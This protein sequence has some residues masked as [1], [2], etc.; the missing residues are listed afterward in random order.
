[1]R[2]QARCYSRRSPDRVKTLQR[3][4]IIIR[5]PNRILLV[6]VKSPFDLV[7]NFNNVDKENRAKYKAKAAEME[8]NARKRVIVYTF[9]VGALGSWDP[10]NDSL[11]SSLGFS[12]PAIKKLASKMT[13]KALRES[14]YIYEQHRYVE[15]LTPE[16]VASTEQTRIFTR[17]YVSAL[18][19]P[20]PILEAFPDC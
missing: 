1:M 17:P 15:K 13:I 10:L 11:L 4:D 9:I 5:F 18:Q 14:H 16:E 3:P 2:S 7:S 20:D 19:A 12:D 8:Y 6:D